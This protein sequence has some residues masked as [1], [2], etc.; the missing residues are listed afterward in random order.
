MQCKFLPIKLGKNLPSIPS[1]TELHSQLCLM[2]DRH[3]QVEH[4]QLLLEAACNTLQYQ[5]DYQQHQEYMAMMAKM[6]F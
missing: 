2:L 1:L 3:H 4:N 5:L 6:E